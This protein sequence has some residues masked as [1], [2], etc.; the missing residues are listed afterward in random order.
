MLLSKLNNIYFFAAILTVIVEDE[1]DNNP[2]FRRS[3]YRRS[4]T[5]NSK[6]GVTIIN[7]VADDAD[8]NRT[9]TYSLEGSRAATDLVHLDIETGE[10][11]VANKIDHEQFPWLNFTVRATDSGIPSRSSFVEVFI[12]VQDEND[13]NPY[14][15]SDIN[16]ITVREDAPLGK[17]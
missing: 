10:I 7:V 2:K 14:F 3:F 11:V 13:N 4:I 1:N 9:I 8:K 15:V 6:N 12:Q 5:E 17:F 16:N